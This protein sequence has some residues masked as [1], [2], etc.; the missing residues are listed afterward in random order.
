MKKFFTLMASAVVSLMTTALAVQTPPVGTQL[1]NADFENGQ[2][3]FTNGRVIALQCL[4]TNGGAGYYFNGAAVKSELFSAANLYRVVTVGERFKLQSVVNEAEYVGRASNDNNALVTMVASDNAETFVAA[5]ATPGNWDTKPDEVVAGTNTIRFT[6]SVGSQFLNTNNTPLVPKYFTGAGGFSA[7]YVYAFTDEEVTALTTI[8]EVDVALNFTGLAGENLTTTQSLP[9]G[10][11]ITDVLASYCPDFFTS[12]GIAEA[13]ATVSE[14]NKTFT[15]NGTWNYPFTLNRVFRADLRKSAA[16]SCTKWAVQSDGQI[17]TRS[18]GDVDQFAPQN[19]FYLKGHGYNNDNRLIVTLHSIAYGDNY[20]FN[21]SSTNN[22][23]GSVTDAPTSWVIKTNSQSTATDKGVSLQHIDADA[24]HVNDISGILGV[25]NATASQNDGGSFI[26]FFDLT[27]SDFGTVQW[28]HDGDYYALDAEKM[29]A[30]QANPTSENVREVFATATLATSATVTV[31]LTHNG[32]LVQTVEISGIVGS[33]QTIAAPTFFNDVITVTIPGNGGTIDYALTQLALPF[34]HTETTDNMVYQAVHIHSSYEES[35]YNGKTRYTWTYS[36]ADSN[37]IIESVPTDVATNGYADTQLWAFVG[38]IVEGFKIYNKA[39]GLD[40]WLYEDGTASGDHVKVGTTAAGSTWKPSLS[41]TQTAKDG[42]CC[43]STNGTNYI[44]LNVGADNATTLTHWTDNDNGSTCWFVGASEPMLPTAE[45]LDFEEYDGPMNAVGAIDYNGVDFSGAAAIIAAATAD[46][47]D[48][49]AADALRNLIALYNSNVIVN[50]L[51]PNGYYRI[52]NINFPNEYV[53]TSATDDNIYS[54][55]Y[56]NNDYRTDY[57]T[58]FKFEPVA[59]QSDRYYLQSQGK[60]VGH[61]S[62]TGQ[63]DVHGPVQT[64]V[65]EERGEYS[66]VNINHDDDPNVPTRASF[67][68]KDMTQS[69]YNFLHQGGDAGEGSYR[70][71]AW[72]QWAHGSHFYVLKADHID[73]ALENAHDGMNVGFGYFPFPVS[74]TDEDTK[75]YYVYE[76]LHKD[77]GAT[78]ITYKEVESVPAHTAFMVSHKENNVAVLAIGAESAANARRRVVSADGNNSVN[79]GFTDTDKWWRNTED[80]TDNSWTVCGAENVPAQITALGVNA[81]NV[82]YMDRTMTFADGG[83]LTADFMYTAGAKRLDICGMALLDA[84]GNI[85]AGD[86]HTGYS[87]NAKVN[88]VYTLK[89]PTAGT[90]TL[91]YY[92]YNSPS[93]WNTAG[94]INLTFITKDHANL[95]HG[96][97]RQ[98]QAQAGDYVLGQTSEGL[99]FVKA[100]EPTAVAGNFVYIPAE[101]IYD[102]GL[103]AADEMPLVNRVNT[104][105]ISE[106]NVEQHAAPKAIYDLQGRRLSA[107]VKG[108][109]II[110][111]AKVLVK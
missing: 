59:G 15:V 33:K 64:T 101:K 77:T 108:L 71:T 20:G 58:I 28:E 103:I 44:N 47:Y 50:Q 7:W 52:R 35:A 2:N 82:R 30:A 84:E 13:D 48:L 99:G 66:L 75:L 22:S 98:D 100:A 111:G 9:S 79:D 69:D 55:R 88:K 90:Y 19:L 104:T 61:V 110:N 49:D 45:G 76:S 54:K 24:A 8:P 94:D 21:C 91:R 81:D 43:L 93:E 32:R 80:L 65:D 72:R 17:S 16:N 68:I 4:D 40:M 6:S 106:L 39:A 70:I 92:C 3:P 73:V 63:N 31:N 86:F 56:L 87:G 83:D 1:V 5:V 57:H 42:Y 25:W 89:V 27:D 85:L 78:V 34:K 62:G 107:P 38:N 29:A 23:T 60:Y 26:R 36:E 12:T 41:R 11:T 14:T 95:L 96:Y 67:A 46:K 74:T 10:T 18:N 37:T 102:K 109:N 53:F 105:G 97:L 51:E